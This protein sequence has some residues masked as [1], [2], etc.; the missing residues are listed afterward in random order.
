MNYGF[1]KSKIDG[2][3]DIFKASESIE[4]PS[5]Y[6]YI[7]YL[8]NVLNQG[9]K[10]ICVPCSI[11]A[12]VNWKMNLVDGNEKDN[13][14]DLKSIY[15]SRSNSS[16]DGMS[17]K[18]ALHFMKH[19]GVDTDNGLFK[20]KGYAMVGSIIQLK[21]ALLINGVCIGGLPVYNSMLS[22]FWKE[23]GEFEGGHAIAIVGYDEEGFII[24]N[25]WGKSYGKDGYYHLKYDDFGDSFYE[26]WTMY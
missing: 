6:S 5:R 23:G 1:I 2:S 9:S 14:I 12:Y 19:E 8:P 26:I 20:I 17:F 21:Y 11:S 16:D 25:S 18:D 13:N 22:E 3:E 7:N 10:P 24:R 4:L 15:S